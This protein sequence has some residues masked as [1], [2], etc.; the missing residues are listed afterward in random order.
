MTRYNLAPFLTLFLAAAGCDGADD[1]DAEYGIN[2]AGDEENDALYEN[3]DSVDFAQLRAQLYCEALHACEP[4]AECAPN[5]WRW[6]ADECESY[7]AVQGAE[8]LTA[9]D[10]M[11]NSLTGGSSAN[12]CVDAMNPIECNGVIYADVDKA[13]CDTFDEEGGRPIRDAG[14]VLLP[15]IVNGK[16]WSNTEAGPTEHQAAARV[17]LRAAQSEHGSIAAFSRLS[18]ELMAHGA[19]PELIIRCHTAALDEIAHARMCLEVARSFG[20]GDV[21]FGA[22]PMPTPRSARLAELACEA[23]E[24]GCVEEGIAAVRARVASDRCD[25]AISDTLRTIA[26][27]ETRHAQLAWA[28]LDWMLGEDPSL[29]LTLVAH[30]DGLRR[31]RPAARPGEAGPNLE[32]FGLLGAADRSAIRQDVV[33]Q[34]VAPTLRSLI[35]KHAHAQTTVQLTA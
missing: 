7:D 13:S 31:R 1:L 8:C 28:T 16:A 26:D 34:I 18:Q 2:N 14:E 35:A 32:S 19:P 29:A 24:E 10:N 11:V 33:E 20:A 12:A 27:D 15:E 23:L 3:V 4:D 17:W 21:D 5:S 9:A 25:G 22:V 6:R 30:L